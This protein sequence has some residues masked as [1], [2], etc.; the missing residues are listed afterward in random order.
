MVAHRRH[1]LKM[2]PRGALHS[3]WGS[4]TAGLRAASQPHREA[5]RDRHLKKLSEPGCAVL[6]DVL[7]LRMYASWF[8]P[9]C[10]L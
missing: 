6:F 3:R 5:V 7:G 2:S 8:Q 1:Q 9:E 4:I 10:I